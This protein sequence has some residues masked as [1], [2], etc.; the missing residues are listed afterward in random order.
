[1]VTNWILSPASNEKFKTK[2]PIEGG[3]RVS[4]AYPPNHD[5]LEKEHKEKIDLLHLKKLSRKLRFKSHRLPLEK[6]IGWKNNL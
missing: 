3:A 6:Y 5:L 2:S 4:P 1:M